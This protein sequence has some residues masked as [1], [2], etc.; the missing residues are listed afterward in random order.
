MS[1]TTFGKIT[2]SVRDG[3]KD[4]HIMVDGV[5]VGV[6]TVDYAARNV[7]ATRR[8]VHRAEAVHAYVDGAGF[9]FEIPARPVVGNRLAVS[10][11][12]VKREIIA[13]TA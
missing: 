3:A 4:A 13:R 1:N 10:I 6:L 12:R 5:V 8:K 9:A 11:A 2:G 7:G